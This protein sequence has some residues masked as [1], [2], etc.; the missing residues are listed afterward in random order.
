MS[1]APERLVVIWTAAD[2]DTMPATVSA[3]TP[4][5]RDFVSG[6]PRWAEG[7]RV[8]YIRADIAEAE[9]ATLRAKLAEAREALRPFADEAE[10]WAAWSDD[11]PLVEGFPEYYGNVTVGNLRFA[12]AT[13]ARIA[14]DAK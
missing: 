10:A 13:L 9:A 6:A 8:E 11:E 1:D 14:E 2:E 7:A 4:K 5:S 12:R 3:H